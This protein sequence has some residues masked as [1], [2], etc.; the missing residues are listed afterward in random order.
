[1]LVDVQFDQP[2][3]PITQMDDSELERRTGTQENEHAFC[4]WTEYWL[5]GQMV[6]RSVHARLKRLPSMDSITGDLQ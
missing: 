6:H 1:M 3:G 4:D 2:N 5:N